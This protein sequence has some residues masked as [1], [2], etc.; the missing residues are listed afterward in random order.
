[1]STMLTVAALAAPIDDNTGQVIADSLLNW[2]RPF[3]L[4][5]V[6]ALA[7]Y[8]LLQKQFSK[9]WTT[10]IIGAVVFA[11]TVGTGESSLVGRVAGWMASWFS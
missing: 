7:L 9:V 8:F 4:V 2:I 10:I 3:I 5:G 6:L 11:L 1:M